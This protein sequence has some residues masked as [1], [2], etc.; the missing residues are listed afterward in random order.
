MDDIKIVLARM[1]ANQESLGKRLNDMGGTTRTTADA[2]IKHGVM[3]KEL[4]KVRE[5]EDER[6]KKIQKHGEALSGIKAT[7]ATQRNLIIGI[8]LSLGTM[9]TWIIRKAFTNQ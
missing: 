2:V 1:E 6:D 4:N 3:L 7:V 9:A 5:R 8:F